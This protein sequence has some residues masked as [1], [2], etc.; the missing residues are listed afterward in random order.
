M[1]AWHQI[2]SVDVDTAG[3][4]AVNV[5]KL[6]GGVKSQ[7]GVTE[8]VGY[9]GFVPPNSSAEWIERAEAAVQ[10]FLNLFFVANNEPDKYRGAV[11]GKAPDDGS[12]NH[13]SISLT[14]RSLRS[15]G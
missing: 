4:G 11:A 6:A 8:L 14:R 9:R 15:D 1:Q 5:V 13:N 12:S 3:R 7:I 2:T 10:E